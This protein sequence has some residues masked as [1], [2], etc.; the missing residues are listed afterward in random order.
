M[1]QTS[2]PD[3]K[4][5]AA[6]NLTLHPLHV[7]FRGCVVAYRI[8]SV[9][10]ESYFAMRCDS[11]DMDQSRCCGPLRRYPYSGMEMLEDLPGKI[12]LQR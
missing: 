12:G 6:H 2:Q 8:F 3:R 4:Q 10:G 7:F 1:A 5:E 11:F 9:Q